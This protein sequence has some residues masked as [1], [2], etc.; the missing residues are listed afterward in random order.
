MNLH[1]DEGEV[2]MKRSLIV[3]VLTFGVVVGTLGP[4]LAA[5][6]GAPVVQERYSF[7]DGWYADFWSDVC[8][9]D[10]FV[11]MSVKGKVKF[12]EDGAIA[13]KVN[14][15]QVFSSP[16]TGELLIFQSAHTYRTLAFEEYD[17]E[18]GYTTITWDDSYIGLAS[19]WYKPGEG[20]LMRDAGQLR[21]VG[22]AVVDF[23]NPDEPVLISLDE[24]VSVKGPH[25]EHFTEFDDFVAMVCAALGA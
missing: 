4:A 1:A 10:V 6:Q 9:I 24:D 25:P 8:G 23:S 19:K 5:G 21:G 7:E 13:D 2:E 18:T 22:T 16:D 12:Y 17:E 3:F 11:E 20:V 15:W 14:V